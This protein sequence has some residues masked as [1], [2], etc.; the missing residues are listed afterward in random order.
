MGMKADVMVCDYCGA[1]ITHVLNLP[2]EGWP[3]LHAICTACF[4]KLHG[5]GA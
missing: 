5:P 3:N 1:T 4:L 2:A